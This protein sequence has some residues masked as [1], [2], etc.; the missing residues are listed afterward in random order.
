MKLYVN[1]LNE[2]KSLKIFLEGA[3]VRLIQNKSYV[4]CEVVAMP[5]SK[6]GGFS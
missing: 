3:L 2:V 1:G 5:C 6:F 4:A